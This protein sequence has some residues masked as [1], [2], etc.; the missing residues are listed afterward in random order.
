MVSLV[1]CPGPEDGP[2][3]W[4]VTGPCVQ[5]MMSSSPCLRPCFLGNPSM[6][7]TPIED[8]SFSGDSE[9]RGSGNFKNWDRTQPT[10]H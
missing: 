10:T 9:S 6:Q 4:K 3:R 8:I 2:R 7:A 5:A 1:A